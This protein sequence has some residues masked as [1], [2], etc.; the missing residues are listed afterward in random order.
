MIH[1]YVVLEL[2]TFILGK[3]A[4]KCRTKTMQITLNLTTTFISDKHNIHPL[5][6]MKNAVFSDAIFLRSWKIT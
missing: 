2:D 6:D 3:N 4:L 1:S 5:I